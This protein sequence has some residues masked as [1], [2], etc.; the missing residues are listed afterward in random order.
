MSGTARLFE[1]Y[2]VVFQF[3]AID[4][5]AFPPF[6]TGNIF[7]G[8]L[9]SFLQSANRP[10]YRTLFESPGA[11]TPPRPFVLRCRNLDGRRYAPG[12][13][14]PLRLNL[15]LPDLDLLE[16]IG[17]ALTA[18]S[19][20][21]FGPTRS[22]A[23]LLSPPAHL[24]HSLCLDEPL[25]PTK[26][27]R[28][29]FQTPTEIKSNG[30]IVAP[31]AFSVLFEQ[32]YGRLNRLS[33][34]YG[35]GELSADYKALRKQA[36]PVLLHSANLSRVDVSR[37]G[38]RLRQT[39]PLGGCVGSVEYGGELTRFVPFLEAAAFTGVGRH[40]VWGNGEIATER[41]D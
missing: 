24:R 7:R 22:R 21:G 11:G 20:A 32:I 25:E 18:M 27:I 12:E 10:A 14:F 9:G 2:S 15:F 36:Q 19:D 17:A 13:I 30:E 28:V 34:L 8:A 37:R 5:F 40:T 38:T 35:S 41:L 16:P 39:H 6:L 31:G 23:T 1:F 4:P 33:V 3:Q 26:A 29:Q